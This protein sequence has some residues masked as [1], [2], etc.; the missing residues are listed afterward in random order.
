VAMVFGHWGDRLISSYGMGIRDVLPSHIRLIPYD[1]RFAPRHEKLCLEQIEAENT[2]DALV[3]C[4]TC[5]P[6]NTPLLMH[7]AR[8]YPIV[9]VDRIPVGFENGDLPWDAAMTDN[10]GSMRAGMQLLHNRGHQR[11]A[12]FMSEVALISSARDRF[13]AYRQFMA[14]QGVSDIA[15]WVREVPTSLPH[16]EY[17][18]R[19]EAHLREL[20]SGSEPITA[21]C[22]Q[23]D[24]T[25]AAVLEA[26]VHLQIS[27]P[28][29]LEIFSFSDSDPAMLP[30]A[31]S[32]NRCEQRTFE[33]GSMAGRR[34]MMRMENPDLPSQIMRL[35][36]DIHPASAARP[37]VHIEGFR[38]PSGRVKSRV[39]RS[40]LTV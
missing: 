13:D 17:Y 38:K 32:V 26:C 30:L 28:Q 19:V 20:L 14:E 2:T 29:E 9:F 25:M 11:I 40:K 35:L 22:C 18:D 36:A 4:P 15:P 37:R 1:S 21:V 39:S 8:K 33:M 7:L 6:E 10:F 24:Q 31:R 27:V 34:L 5:A 16:Q 3:L 12:Y 23:Q